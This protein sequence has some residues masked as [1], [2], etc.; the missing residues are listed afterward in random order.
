MDVNKVIVSFLKCC[1]IQSIC[2]IMLYGFRLLPREVT[3]A[4]IKS[5]ALQI[6]T[7]T[8][9]PLGIDQ[10]GAHETPAIPATSTKQAGLM[11]LQRTDSSAYM[12]KVH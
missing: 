2:V 12:Q 6:D 3:Q 4:A 7:Q 9:M 5:G 10:G 8:T 11:Q 1:C